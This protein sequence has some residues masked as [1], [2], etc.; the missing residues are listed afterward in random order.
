MACALLLPHS[1]RPV[2]ANAVSGFGLGWRAAAIGTTA[3][4]SRPRRVMMVACPALASARIAGSCWRACSA[5]FDAGLG[6]RFMTV[7][8]GPYGMPS[9]TAGDEGSLAM[10]ADH[11]GK[12]RQDVARDALAL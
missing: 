6:V 4:T 5:P 2:P 7:L 9:N 8:Y 10:T 3:A 1:P 12:L 11:Y